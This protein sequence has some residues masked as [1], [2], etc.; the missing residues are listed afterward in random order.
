MYSFPDPLWL[1]GLTLISH[2]LWT[3]SISFSFWNL[4]DIFVFRSSVFELPDELQQLA[5]SF[6]VDF[7]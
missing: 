7:H 4:Y 5:E 2:M 3:F 6:P 1:C